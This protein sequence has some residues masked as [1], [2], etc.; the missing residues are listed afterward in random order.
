[1]EL[2]LSVSVNVVVHDQRLTVLLTDFGLNTVSQ[3]RESFL[4]LK[5]GLLKFSW[6]R[7]DWCGREVA[8]TDDRLCTSGSSSRHAALRCHADVKI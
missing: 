7:C 4:K 3:A 1:M 8:G 6:C 5:I 2:T